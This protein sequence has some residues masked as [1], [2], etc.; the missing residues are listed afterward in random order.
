MKLS[1]RAWAFIWLILVLGILATF[2]AYL[3]WEPAKAP[4]FTFAILVALATIAQLLRVEAPTHQLYYAT[5]AFLFAGLILLPPFLFVCLVLIPY[6]IQ[7]AKERLLN[8]PH[9]KS[10]YLQPFN[11]SNHIITGT[12]AHYFY[13]WIFPLFEKPID[14]PLSVV[15]SLLTAALYVMINHLLTGIAI[16]L[17]R[18]VSFRKSGILDLSN[19]LSDFV[20]ACIGIGITVVWPIN[21]WFIIPL[22][23]PLMVMYRA[24]K[25]PLLQR[26]AQ[27]DE[28]T[29]LAN[30]RHFSNTLTAEIQ[31][32]K[33][34][35]RPLSLIMS[36]L[37]LLR[38]VNNTY[39]HLAG[40]AV[41]AGIGQ[42]IRATIR[43]YDFAGRLGG[44][45]FAIALPETDIVEAQSIAERIRQTIENT[46]FE[47]PTN[48]SA[49]RVTMSFGISS[50]PSDGSTLNALIHQADVAVFQAKLKGRNRVELAANVPQ[51]AKLE[52]IAQDD[53]LAQTI[54]P[55]AERPAPIIESEKGKPLLPKNT[56]S[57]SPSSPS[58]RL[59]K[60][61]VAMVI[62]SGCIIAW[63]GFGQ[64]T[65][66]WVTIIILSIVAVFGEL[67]QVRLYGDSTL[68]VSATISF[69]AALIT[70]IPGIVFVSVA[71]VLTHWVR[72]LRIPW[73]KT[74]FNWATHVI[75]ASIPALAVRA[76]GWSINVDNFLPLTLFALVVSIVYYFVESG[77]VVTAIS[78]FESKSV[79]VTWRQ[80]FGWMVAYYLALGIMGLFLAIIY[81][82]HEIGMVGIFAFLMPMFIL[83][84]AQQQYVERTKDSVSELER[85]N[86]ELS[87]ANRQVNLANQSIRQMNDELFLTLAMIIDARDPFVSGHAAQVAQY[88]DAIAKELRLAPERAEHVRQSALLH[89]IGKIGIPERVL[90]KPAKLTEQEYVFIQRHA[91]L[92]AQFLDTAQGLRHLAPFIRHHHEWWNGNGYPSGLKGEQIPLEARI[93]AVCDAVEAMASDRAYHRAMSLEDIIAELK[94]CAGIQFDPRVVDAFVRVAERHGTN[95]VV[96][97]AREIVEKRRHTTNFS[98]E[99]DIPGFDAI[100]LMGLSPI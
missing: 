47:I 40:D 51:S 37:D 43:D 39:G 10:W 16:M 74:F 70:G 6:L 83:Y 2:S 15:A 76:L 85:M 9:L 1:K 17:A 14:S 26:E 48:P 98:R 41:L 24:L 38:N 45:E 92:G 73:Y 20:L 59:G 71:I 86:Q 90:N 78:L 81:V 62:I 7:W 75:A 42:V 89:D 46:Q 99:T 67:F 60:L 49:I 97:S 36:D 96:N 27:T 66:D 31:R 35:N 44:E 79:L 61:F 56:V 53:R 57:P 65:P 88:A 50:F 3:A 69:A 19:L 63:L 32:A 29:G 77:L 12:L 95:L 22:L 82:D 94:R 54:Y 23:S 4:W 30:A 34:F 21:P 5:Y 64:T 28:K 93:L 18:H 8:S 55:I 52:S 80:E 11:I 72:N 13:L 33:R 25:V 100:Q 84:Y 68:S 87:L 91:E 58:Q